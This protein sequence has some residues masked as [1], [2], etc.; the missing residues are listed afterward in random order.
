MASEKSEL[1]WVTDRSLTCHLETNNKKVINK[2]IREWSHHFESGWHFVRI[3]VKDHPNSK[4]CFYSLS[5]DT[6]RPAEIFQYFLLIF[7]IP[8]SA[9]FHFCDEMIWS[10]WNP[11]NRPAKQ[12][13]WWQKE[14]KEKDDKVWVLILWAQVEL[15]KWV[16]QF[17]KN[18]SYPSLI[19][20]DQIKIIWGILGWWI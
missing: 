18:R 9:V 6:V 15:T 11:H 1:K 3:L 7:Q 20:S 4:C 12:R 13:E 10:D 17:I 19:K 16:N 8:V 14:K 2:R 5:T